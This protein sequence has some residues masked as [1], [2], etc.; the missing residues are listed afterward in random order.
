MATVNM[1]YMPTPNR[2]YTVD[3][4][5]LNG[6][7]NL[8]ELDYRLKPNESPQMRNLLWRDGV[9]CSRD[10]QEWQIAATRSGS[11]YDMYDKPFHG[12][13]IAHVGAKMLY[14]T[15]RGSSW[16][17]FSGVSIAQ[18]AGTFFVYN[19]VLYYKNRGGYYKITYDAETDSLSC[20]AVDP[21]I[22]I[23]VINAVPD[24]N[25]SFGGGSTYQPENRLQAKKTVWYN[26]SGGRVYYLPEKGVSGSF[27]EV[28]VDGVPKERGADKAFTL[29]PT[30]GVVYFTEGNA[31]P[32]TDPPTNN[33]VVITY[34]KANSDAYDS[35]MSC[36]LAAT[37]GGTGELCVVMGG[38]EAQPNAIFWNTIGRGA[39][40]DP[41]YFPMEQYQLVGG[42]EDPVTGF[43]KQQSFLVVFKERS[44]GRVKQDMVEVDG[45]VRI[46][47]PYVAINAKIGCDLP[48][49]IQLINNNL[50][51]CNTD[52]GVHIL[53]DSSYAYEN[54]IE[55]VSTKVNG[56]QKKL[57]LLD[58]VR[59]VNSGAPETICSMDDEK[60]YWLCVGGICWVW[61]YEFS[62]YKD[63]SWYYMTG[64]N[65]RA[66]CRDYEDI[67]HLDGSGR[68][69]R[70]VRS[71]SDYGEAIDKSYR[72]ATQ[73]FGGYDRLKNVNSVIISVRP[74]TNS[75][76]TV[77]YLTDY[78]TRRDLTNLQNFVWALVPWDLEHWS[79][80]GV[81]FGVAFRRRP[82]CR[83][84][85]HFTMQLDNATPFEDLSIVSAQIFYNFQGRLR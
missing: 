11:V 25:G 53:K 57:G 24:N 21:Y 79:L 75:E 85:K 43:G 42:S 65:A 5:M 32:V 78:E 72:F 56:S 30:N 64:I 67:W 34:S 38:C 9:L 49:T 66:F 13:L 81:G 8:S 16:S 22:P 2:E 46:D 45:R 27:I 76:T 39:A 41:T 50:V 18:S 59:R 47:M 54:N 68:L 48:K 80:A 83:R 1:K 15:L 63:P 7:L 20:A 37:Y 6:G 58:N 55:C 44:T 26:A 36:N 51:W 33:T 12:F 35:I 82:M 52:Q 31:P 4:Y 74:D 28:V 14:T 70:F 71:Y 3:L 60:R 29:D 73:Y 61:D 10:G 23:I 84:V 19:D 17:E 40:M 62:T 77:T 69:T